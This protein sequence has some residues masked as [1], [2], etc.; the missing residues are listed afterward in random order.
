[1]RAVVPDDGPA[2]GRSATLGA[3]GDVPID[4]LRPARDPFE[5]RIGEAALT[6]GRMAG[7]IRG[8]RLGSALDARPPGLRARSTRCFGDWSRRRCSCCPMPTWRSTARSVRRT[9]SS[10]WPAR[11]RPGAPLGLQAR[12][13]RGPGR[14]A[15][16]SDRSTASRSPTRSS[17][18]SRWSSPGSGARSGRTRPWS[19]GSTATDFRSTSPLR[20]LANA[21]TFAL[22]GWRF[23][24]VD[25][26]READ[27]R[28]RRRSRAA[29]R[30]HLPRS[31]RRARL[32]LQQRD[33][34]DAA[35]GVRA[36]AAESG[37]WAHRETLIAAGRA[38]FEYAQRTPV[39][40]LELL[41][42]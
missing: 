42:T 8:R 34:L 28:G 16:T 10:S 9:R 7:S 18:A 14:T 23:E 6:D 11:G 21:S 3:Q 12:Q 24:A 39:P 5:L 40:E 26:S 22:T 32:L 31:R 30:R 35:A 37:G 4:E 27:R 20:V 2:P 17:M 19:G 13:Q 36:G 41:T 25:G 29:R 38:H 15:T 1:M 33:R